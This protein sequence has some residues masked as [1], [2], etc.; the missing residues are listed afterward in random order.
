MTK[1]ITT[2]MDDDTWKAAMLANISWAEAIKLGAKILLGGKQKLKEMVKEKNELSA[3][4]QYVE[5]QIKLIEK[6]KKNKENYDSEI[7]KHLK[8]LETSAEIINR[9]ISF[10]KG[11][12]RVWVNKTGIGVT[13]EEF[14]QL[15]KR[16]DRGEFR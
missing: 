5:N 12:R 8:L 13:A 16:F 14:Y 6:N 9:D 7:K 15:C 10:L 4:L 1:K 2:C 3:R 11:R